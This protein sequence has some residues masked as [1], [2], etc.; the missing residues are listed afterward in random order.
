MFG[1]LFMATIH[2]SK[3][4][5]EQASLPT[6]SSD[7][8]YTVRKILASDALSR[9]KGYRARYEPELVASSLAFA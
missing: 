7:R 5:I 6:R 1:M 2:T 3:Q 8:N 4:S 9:V